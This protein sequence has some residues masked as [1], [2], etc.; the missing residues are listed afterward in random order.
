MGTSEEKRNR[1]ISNSSSRARKYVTRGDRLAPV[2]SRIVPDFQFPVAAGRGPSTKPIHPMPEQC[3][4]GTGGADP[5]CSQPREHPDT[6]CSVL[7][8]FQPRRDP[9]PVASRLDRTPQ[10]HLHIAGMGGGMNGKG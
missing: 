6:R 8:P 10:L 5:D 7:S 2:N 3:R 4:S 1:F 9:G